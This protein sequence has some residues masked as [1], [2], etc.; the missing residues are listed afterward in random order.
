MPKIQNNIKECLLTF[1]MA[2]IIAFGFI[3]GAGSLNWG[4]L[5]DKGWV[6]IVAGIIAIMDSVIAGLA[7]Y[8]RFLKPSD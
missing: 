4:V 5:G 7:F 6:Y 2:L 3:G 8:K 1:V